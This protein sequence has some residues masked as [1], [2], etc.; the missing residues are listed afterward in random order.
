MVI[1]NIVRA[2]ALTSGRDIALFMPQSEVIEYSDN[3]T[4]HFF[5]GKDLNES[6]RLT[7]GKTMRSITQETYPDLTEKEITSLLG[8]YYIDLLHDY[9]KDY[10]NWGLWADRDGKLV[11]F[12]STYFGGLR[13]GGK[14][15]RHHCHGK[16]EAVED[17]VVGTSINEILEEK[18]EKSAFVMDS[19]YF[20]S[21]LP[22]RLKPYLRLHKDTEEP[23]V[24]FVDVIRMMFDLSQFEAKYSSEPDLANELETKLREVEFTMG[25]FTR[26]ADF[27]KR[28]HRYTSLDAEWLK[29]GLYVGLEERRTH[30]IVSNA[31]IDQIL[32]PE[33]IDE[34]NGIVVGANLVT[35]DDKAYRNKGLALYNR[36]M[37]MF[38]LRK[39]IGEEKFRQM[40]QIADVTEESVVRWTKS[41]GYTEVPHGK[42]RWLVIEPSD[43]R[44]IKATLVEE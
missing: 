27:I 3:L 10:T 42:R 22:L 14:Y 44:P 20:T 11:G 5:R 2:S 1:E 7:L 4:V 33:E 39:K 24:E 36:L 19:D 32:I 34:M 15:I 35:L 23:H 8:F 18:K 38:K 6:Q 13:R 40:I 31:G 21:N 9:E 30:K 37:T 26:L 16:Q 12:N 41:L 28:F 17:F 25:D 43:E 29:Q